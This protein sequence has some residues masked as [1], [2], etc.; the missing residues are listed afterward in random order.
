[1]T[2]ERP[3]NAEIEDA[4]LFAARLEIIDCQE[5][6]PV[7]LED[8]APLL[9]LFARSRARQEAEHDNFRIKSIASSTEELDN[10]TT[11]MQ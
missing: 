10:D 9:A 2:D 8:L 7:S 3:S 5:K 11:I 4:L 6:Q 1:M